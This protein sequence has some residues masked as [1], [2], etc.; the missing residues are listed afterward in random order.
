LVR[1]KKTTSN[2]RNCAKNPLKSKQRN[3][4][5][6]W[7]VLSAASRGII[8]SNK[9]REGTEKG[10]LKDYSQVQGSDQK[11]DEEWGTRKDRAWRAGTL[12]LGKEVCRHKSGQETRAKSKAEEKYREIP[13]VT[14]PTAG[15]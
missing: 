8:D 1:P 2:A 5:E 11:K 15:T 4:G 7:E 3:S 13:G 9:D 14:A 12:I 10:C 6:R